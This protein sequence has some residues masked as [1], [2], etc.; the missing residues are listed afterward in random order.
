MLFA[1]VVLDLVSLVLIQ[2]IGQEKHRQNDLSA[3]LLSISECQG[4]ILT[5]RGPLCQPDVRDPTYDS[6][7]L[8]H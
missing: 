1:F 5:G 3:T 4:S 7:K 2:K 6:A 8:F